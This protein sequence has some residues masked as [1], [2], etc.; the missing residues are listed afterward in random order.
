MVRVWLFRF[1]TDYNVLRI[2]AHGLLAAM[3][4]ADVETYARA[5]VYLPGH[6]MR[7]GHPVLPVY[8]QRHLTGPIQAC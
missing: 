3:P 7:L 4:S 8:A 1:G 6:L 5:V 2:A